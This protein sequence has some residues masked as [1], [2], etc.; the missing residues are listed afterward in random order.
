M[1]LK[2]IILIMLMAALVS[3][4]ICFAD[5]SD[6]RADRSRY[7]GLLREIRKIDAEYSKVIK[8]AME[9]AKENDNGSASLETKSRLLA[10]RDK[11]DRII[12]RLTILSLRNGWEMPDTSTPEATE[13]IPDEKERV[14]E[15]AEQIIKNTFSKEACRIVKTINLPLVPL[16]SQ[17]QSDNKGKEDKKWLLF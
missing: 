17:Q 13:K 5:S 6:T 16:Q 7:D 14:F 11:R 2:R 1:K 8:K 12:N 3:T 4:S 15:P 9:E 10:L